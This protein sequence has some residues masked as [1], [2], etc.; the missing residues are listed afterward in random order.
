MRDLSIISVAWEKR[1]RLL[2]LV[3]RA[4]F[5]LQ[6][7]PSL[8]YGRRFGCGN[9]VKTFGVTTWEDRPKH[10]AILQRSLRGNL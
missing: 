1:K 5:L 3:S 8:I 9:P 10:F 2:K 4:F 7:R 6:A